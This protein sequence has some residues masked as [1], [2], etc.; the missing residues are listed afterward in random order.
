LTNHCPSVLWHCW[1]GHLTRK[2]VSEMTYNVSNGTLNTNIP[3]HLV[4]TYSKLVYFGG[5][6]VQQNHSMMRFKSILSAHSDL[7]GR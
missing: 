3:Y 2:I 6:T 7:G 4:L 5:Q 1:L